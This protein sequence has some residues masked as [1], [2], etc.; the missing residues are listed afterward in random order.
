MKRIALALALVA[1]LTFAT[2]VQ[3]VGQIIPPTD[4][5]GG[6]PH[7]F[8]RC[9]PERSDLDGKVIVFCPF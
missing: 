7:V 3:A 2:A 1:S 5:G 6:T 4:R 9:Y 8:H